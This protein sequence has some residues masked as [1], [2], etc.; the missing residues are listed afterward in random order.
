MNTN[1]ITHTE[2]WIQKVV[3]GL[4]LCPFAAKEVKNNTIR[5]VVIENPDIEEL[6]KTIINECIYLDENAGT[7]T[8]L[9]ILPNMLTDF[10]EYLDL[11][12]LAED[13]LAD[14]E[15]EGIYQIASFHPHYLFDGT[16]E[17]DAANYTNRSPYP[18][19]HLLR[20]ESIDKALEKHPNYENIPDRNIEFTRQKG[21]EYMKMLRDACL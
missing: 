8:T 18:M 16:D 9:L 7:E 14:Q 17:T 20:E 4:N 19:L 2:N 21:V 11:V 12:A 5:Y 1:I 15:Y 6:L 10:E 13:L 3:V